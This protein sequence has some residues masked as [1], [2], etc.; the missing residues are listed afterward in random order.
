VLSL[1]FVGAG[2]CASSE[3]ISHRKWKTPTASLRIRRLLSSS[4]QGRSFDH[5]FDD[6]GKPMASVGKS[7]EPLPALA[8]AVDDSPVPQQGQVVAHSRLAHVKL[9][10]NPPG[11]V[12]PFGEQESS[13][14]D[15]LASSRSPPR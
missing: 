12:L 5:A 1:T 8:A 3:R 2:E 7:V 13:N 15:G 14:E 10:A 4:G 9:V 6:F 11:I